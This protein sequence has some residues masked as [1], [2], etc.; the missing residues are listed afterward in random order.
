MTQLTLKDISKLIRDIDVCMMTTVTSG[1][2][3][4]S[5]PMSNNKEVDYDGSSYFFSLDK[6]SAVQEIEADAQV[7]LAY[8]RQDS[9]F[10][11]SAYISVTGK[12]QLI[13]DKAEFKKHWMKDVEVWF[14]DGIDTPGLVL[15]RVDAQRIKYW[16]GTEEGEVSLTG[17]SSQAA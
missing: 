6:F 12:A 5:R 4:E 16:N 13:R 3:L 17:K 11:K 2:A 10:S 1:E 8:V 7:N 9:L 14:K 15:I